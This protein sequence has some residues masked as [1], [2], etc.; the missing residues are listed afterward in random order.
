MYG[1]LCILST[2]HVICMQ[3]FQGCTH[4]VTNIQ[5]WNSYNLELPYETV[6]LKTVNVAI[7]IQYIFYHSV[8]VKLYLYVCDP[9]YGIKTE[10]PKILYPWYC[11]LYIHAIYVYTV[12]MHVVF[13]NPQYAY[14]FKTLKFTFCAHEENSFNNIAPLYKIC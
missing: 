8:F 4:I 1:L 5:S 6:C 3:P 7:W 2:N 10:I 12:C 14:N 11:I 13:I 9:Q